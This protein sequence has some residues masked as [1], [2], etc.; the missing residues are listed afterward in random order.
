ML[1]RAEFGPRQPFNTINK[2]V[3]PTEFNDSLQKH[4]LTQHDAR[5]IIHFFRN[6]FVH[7]FQSTLIH[8]RTLTRVPMLYSNI[9]LHSTGLAF[10]FLPT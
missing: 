2:Y 9:D 4:L 8:H 3:Y 5:G 1:G 7:N 10:F 6:D